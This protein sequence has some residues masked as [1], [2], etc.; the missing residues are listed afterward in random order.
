[1]ARSF[2]LVDNKIQ[3][4]EYFLDRIL[5]AKQFFF[6]VQCDAVAFAASARSVTFSMQ[7]SLTGL[8]QFDIWYTRKQSELRD[9]PLAKFFHEFRRVSQH[10]GNNVVV[11]G[12]SQGKNTL[13]HFGPVPGLI[14][15]P[16]L[17]V[18]STC[19]EYFKLLLEVVYE[20]YLTFNPLINGQWRFTRQHFESIGKTIE[21]AEEELGYP[22]GWLKVPEFD[23]DTRWSYL[24]RAADGCNIQAQFERWLDKRVPHPDDEV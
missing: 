22:R 7:A 14:N 9:I 21:D 1:M 23:D 12:S 11:G 16:T 3:E 18:A 4:A 24:R 5:E 15:V 13:F 8:P 19:T 10:I 20:G 6:G 2:G 17:D